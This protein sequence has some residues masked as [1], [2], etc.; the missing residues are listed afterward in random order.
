MQIRSYG[1]KPYHDVTKKILPV[2]ESC[3]MF[4][5]FVGIMKD[6]S[7][8]QELGDK[9]SNNKAPGIDDAINVEIILVVAKIVDSSRNDCWSLHN[10][11]CKHRIKRC[12]Q[13]TRN[14]EA[15][16]NTLDVSNPS[17]VRSA[18][19]AESGFV[20]ET[21]SNDTADGKDSN[22]GLLEGTV[23]C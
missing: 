1:Q 22:K 20:S 5:R 6:S 12:G 16:T 2:L 19:I 21:T 23:R 13:Q 8:I 11:C 7:W 3:V 17:N 10:S 18:P 14:S 9:K 4:V 15:V